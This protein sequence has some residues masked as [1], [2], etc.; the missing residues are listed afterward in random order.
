MSEHRQPAFAVSSARSWFEEAPSGLTHI[1]ELRR[2]AEKLPEDLGP[3]FGR[4]VV[5]L[6]DSFSLLVSRVE[7]G[8]N[9]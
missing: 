2:F 5:R 7:S 8:L 6:C 4:D 9:G 3:C 1:E